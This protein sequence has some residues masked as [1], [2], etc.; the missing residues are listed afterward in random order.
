MVCYIIHVEY[1]FAAKKYLATIY[2]LQAGVR[3]YHMGITKDTEIEAMF[4]AVDHCIERMNKVHD[5]QITIS[6]VQ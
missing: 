4:A 5:Y 1:R 3:L 2:L 6:Y